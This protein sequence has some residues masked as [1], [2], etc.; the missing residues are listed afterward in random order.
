MATTP[1]D[2][3]PA[4]RL[5]TGKDDDAFCKRVSGGTGAGIQPVRIA[6][7][8]LR[9]A[10]CRRRAGTDLARLTGLAVRGQVDRVVRATGH[11]ATINQP[12]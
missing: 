9:R 12:L 6:R 8:H 2:D 7:D 11:A 3:M 1:P 4:Y 10:A 5:L